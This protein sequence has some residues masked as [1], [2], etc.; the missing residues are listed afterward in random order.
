VRAV[1]VVALAALALPFTAEARARFSV[2]VE[3]QVQL[4]WEDK[5]SFGG[6]CPT[7]IDS[8]G[9]ETVA[10]RS[11]RPTVVGLRVAHGRVIF[12]ASVTIRALAGGVSGAGSQT[13]QTCNGAT[14]ADLTC[15]AGPFRGGSARLVAPAPGRLR[16]SALR[17]DG[18]PSRA[19]CVPDA[20]RP[21]EFPP[22]STAVTRVDTRRL[23]R[24]RTSVFAASDQG[25]VRLA[26]EGETGFLA[27]QIHWRLTFRRLAG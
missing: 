21:A 4:S 8:T 24:T 20:L 11:S 5:A 12:P 9:Q 23:L 14:H 6:G 22:L 7:T 15:D 17:G 27:R 13:T 25:I 1:L 2:R 3:G 18:L 10:F 16:L 19:P 26:A